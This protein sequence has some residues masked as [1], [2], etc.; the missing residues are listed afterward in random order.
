VVLLNKIL[1]KYINKLLLKT[2]NEYYT[3]KKFY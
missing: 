1:A 2:D 3:K